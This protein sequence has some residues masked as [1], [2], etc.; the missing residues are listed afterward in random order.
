MNWRVAAGVVAIA[1]PALVLVL[2][3]S[4]GPAPVAWPHSPPESP[5]TPPKVLP[6]W[7]RASQASLTLLRRVTAEEAR[8]S[9]R[10]LT[11]CETSAVHTAPSRRP[12]RY[13]K[14][15]LGSISRTGS[16]ASTNS[17]MFSSLLDSAQA[18]R[19]CHDGVLALSGT[20]STLALTARSAARG[21]FSAGWGDMLA[22]SRSIRGLAHASLK[23]ARAPA[24]GRDCRPR[25]PGPPPPA[26]PVA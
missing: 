14:C 5:L 13:R 11:A 7:D 17:H 21:S 20:T 3:L 16:F 19:A 12:A 22:A 10:T 4:S 18:T 25:K 24:L 1:G 9:E 26:G 8:R 23:L 6:R 2:A 15:A